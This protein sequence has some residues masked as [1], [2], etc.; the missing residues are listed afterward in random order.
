MKKKLLSICICMLSIFILASCTNKQEKD[1][2]EIQE[3]TNTESEI[4]D[5]CQN[6]GGLF[7]PDISLYKPVIYLYPEKE[8]DVSVNLTL[9][10]KLTCTYPKYNNGWTV[11]AKPDGTLTDKNG[12]NYNYLYWEGETDTR[13][14]FSTGYCVKGSESAKF[15]EKELAKQGLNRKEANEF[16]TF[17]LPQMEQN[18]YN[19]ISFQKET[20]T[21]DA[22]LNVNPNP[23][24]IIRVFMAFK[25]SNE[26]VKIPVPKETETPQRNGFTLVEWGGSILN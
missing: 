24:T 21:D 25:P 8:T 7:D 12:M 17:W 10:G 6:Q 13:F 18:E 4:D 11:T 23:N 3:T 2:N 14:D 16:I 1:N 15:L 5:N 19:I 9:N 20:Y 26:Y 22:K